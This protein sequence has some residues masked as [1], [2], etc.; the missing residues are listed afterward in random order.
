MIEKIKI[1]RDNKQFCAAILTDLSKAFDCIPYDLP[2]AKL[3]A[4]GFDQEAL[5]LIHSYL[6][7]RSQKVKVG[8]SFS[9]EL[10]IV[11]GVSQ[12]VCQ[13]LVHYYLISIY[14]ICFLLI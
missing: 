3:N 14:V 12:G 9:K 8:S 13:Y 11:C 2:I 1:S 6:Y 5:K 7:D 10:E 4:Y